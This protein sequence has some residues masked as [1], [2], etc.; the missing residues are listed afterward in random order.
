MFAGLFV[1]LPRNEVTDRI[2]AL[3]ASDHD[4][5]RLA[6]SGPSDKRSDNAAQLLNPKSCQK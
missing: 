6:F 1:P 4:R 5:G 2:E 3:Q